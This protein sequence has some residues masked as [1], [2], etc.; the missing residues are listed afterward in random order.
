MTGYRVL[1]RRELLEQWRTMRLGIVVIV[2]L[3]FGLLS[4]VLARYTPELIGS[5]LPPDQLPLRLPT[6]TT[7]D[8]ISQFIKNVG[9]TLTLAGVLLAMGMVASEKERGTAAFILTKP[10]G[11]GAFVAA[12]LTALA[13]T[14]GLAMAASGAAAYAYTGWL[15][16]AP[17][18]GGFAA[19]VLSIWLAQLSIASLTLLGSA[20]VRSV[21]AA[22]ALGFAAYVILALVSALPT[23]GQ[24]TP[25]GLQNAA[26][27]LALGG[28][29]PT[30]VAAVAANLALV[31][32]AGVLA[33]LALRRQEI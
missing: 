2:F 6:P 29:P 15:F 8:A 3:L 16:T 19:M 22:G 5:F 18:I 1:L 12:K 26:G 21:V 11:R 27:E 32:G 33:W 28:M 31:A 7:A 13:V 30:I 20:L 9:G 4:P 10:A 24:Y 17:P 14:L 25:A 23:I